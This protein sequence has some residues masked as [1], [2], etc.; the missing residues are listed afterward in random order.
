MR[1]CINQATAVVVAPAS[2]GLSAPGWVLRW[3]TLVLDGVQ[4]DCGPGYQPRVGQLPDTCS[5]FM[6]S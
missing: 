5:L 3:L 2:P 6:W 4:H 1:I